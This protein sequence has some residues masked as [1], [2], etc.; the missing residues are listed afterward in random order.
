MTKPLQ[1]MAVPALIAA[2]IGP[3]QVITGFNLAQAFWPGFDA[4]HHTI[5]DL[6]ADDSPVQ[7]LMTSFFYLGGTLSIVVAIWARTFALPGR[8]AIGLAG[9]ATYGL[10]YFTTPSQIGHSD[11]HRIF[12][13]ASFVLSAGWPLLAMRFDKRYP[14]II[15]PIGAIVGTALLTASALLF[16][17][18]WTDPN[19][20]ATGVWER[21]IAVSQTWYL[22][23]VIWVCWF[24]EKKQ[25]SKG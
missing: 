11:M 16:L 19:A 10:A 1:R 2:I 22:A 24:T 4:V 13:V 15:R 3:I 18:S 7:V 12:A 6:A 14:W 21:I 5:S 25:T 23:L 8:I 20:P 17:A 9:L